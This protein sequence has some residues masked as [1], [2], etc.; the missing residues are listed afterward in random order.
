MPLATVADLSVAFE[1]NA[2]CDHRYVL[3]LCPICKGVSKNVE[4]GPDKVDLELFYSSCPKCS[5]DR[6]GI[7]DCICVEFSIADVPYS[8][9]I[10]RLVCHKCDYHWWTRIRAA[11]RCENCNFVWDISSMTTTYLS[12]CVQRIDTWQQKDP[13]IPSKG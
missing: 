1:R 11:Y 5:T 8:F 7:N 2:M 9:T 6:V 10:H 12:G 13:L 4:R 3:R